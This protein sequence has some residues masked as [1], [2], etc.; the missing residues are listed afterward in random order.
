MVAYQ[1][2]EFCASNSNPGAVGKIRMYL[3]REIVKA[4]APKA[5]A[6]LLRYVEAEFPQGSERIGHQPFRTSLVNGRF[7]SLDYK[8]FD[9]FLP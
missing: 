1:S 4:D 9:A 5:M 7:Q 2:V 6:L 8:T 3:M